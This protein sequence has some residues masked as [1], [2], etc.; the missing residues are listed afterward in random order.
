ML[1]LAVFTPQPAQAANTGNYRVVGY[2]PDWQGDVNAVQYSKLTHVCYAFLMANADGSLNMSGVTTSRLQQLTTLAHNNGTKVIISLGGWSNSYNPDGSEGPLFPA[3]RNA[4]ARANLATNCLNFINQYSLD[5][6]DFDWEGPANATDGAAWSS[7]MQTMYSS[8]QPKGKVTTTAIASWFGSNIPTSAWAYIDFANIMAYDNEGAQHSSYDYAVSQMSYWLGQGIPMNKIVLGV[9][10][11][12]YPSGSRTGVAYNTICAGDPGAHN[13][14]YSGGVYYNGIPTIQAKTNYVVSQKAGG[15]MMWELSQDATGAKSLL[16][17]IYTILSNDPT[18]YTI[19]ASA[20]ANGSISPSGAQSVAGGASKTFTITPN[21]GYIVNAV[22]VD[23]ANIGAVTSYTFSNVTAN[24]TISASFVASPV[25]GNLA[26]GKSASASSVETSAFPASLAVDG[27]VGT[28]WSSTFADPAWIA[29]DLGSSQTFNR[30]V[31][32]WEAAYGKAYQIQV[33]NDN[34]SWSTVYTR[35]AGTGGTEDFTFATTTARYIRM[36]GTAR[37]TVWGYS[38]FEFEVY[39][40]AAPTQYT[41]TASAGSNGAISPSGAVKVNKGANQSFSITPA[42]GYVVDAVLVDGSSVG[43]VTSYTFSNVQ[44]A[45]SISATFKTGGV[46]QFTLTASAGS[47]G[48]ISPSGAVKVSQGASQTFTI[49]PASG[50]VISSV[51]VDGVSVGAVNTY[52][53]SNV[54][55]AHIISATF[56]SSAIPAWAPGVFYAKGALVTYAGSTWKNALE[57]TSN[58]AWY[59]GAP[60][61][62]LWEKQ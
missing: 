60:G 41:I 33:S 1:A 14:D 34:A 7:F 11:Y 47:G 30:V 39:N 53:F 55:A 52:T 27:S 35:T 22:S 18:T 10:F 56:S 2:M 37:G 44:A 46:T 12:G 42:S 43:A 25:N 26:Q 20:G 23:G 6:F 50:Y 40:S 8:L 31:L 21:S 3:M 32:R 13:V 28:R 38:L 19:T 49:T 54:Q 5:G 29:I 48:A 51:T 9:P 4:S 15:V 62:W 16:S 58:S 45:H 17:A 36:Y 24:H 57:H 59:P 61:L